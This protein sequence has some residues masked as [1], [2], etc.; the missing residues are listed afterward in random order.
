MHYF[1]SIL[2]INLEYFKCYQ[3][4]LIQIERN[5]YIYI[6][7]LILFIFQILDFLIFILWMFTLSPKT[8]TLRYQA[9]TAENFSDLYSKMLLVKVKEMKVDY[10]SPVAQIEQT[11]K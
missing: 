11:G 3:F 6:F 1:S 10:F 5:V 8:L 2:K 4:P 7:Y 9:I